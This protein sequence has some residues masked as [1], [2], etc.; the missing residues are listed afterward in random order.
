MQRRCIRWD[1]AL[2][3]Q[4]NKSP[5]CITWFF[6]DRNR[7]HA[8]PT[9]AG[10][11]LGR[12]TG[13]EA[14]LCSNRF[15]DR[16]ALGCNVDR[17]KKLPMIIVARFFTGLTEVSCNKLQQTARKYLGYRQVTAVLSEA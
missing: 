12:T 11:N 17:D 14:K 3:T 10:W 5:S 6:Y 15:E 2:L 1:Y 8:I 4:L 16:Q 13:R 7:G 9:W